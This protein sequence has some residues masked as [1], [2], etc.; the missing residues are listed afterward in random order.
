MVGMTRVMHSPVLLSKKP[1]VDPATSLVNLS[2]GYPFVYFNNELKKFVMFY[3]GW[4]IDKTIIAN[5]I[6]LCAS[7]EDGINFI[8]LDTSP[9]FHEENKILFNQVLPYKING[10]TFSEGQFFYLPQLKSDH[11]FVALCMYKDSKNNFFAVTFTSN[12]GLRFTFHPEMAWHKGFNTPDYPMSIIYNSRL[13]SF[14]IYRRPRHT[15]R[16][17]AFVTT[18]DFIN[19]SDS[20]VILQADALDKPLTDF[21]GINVFHY[22]DQ[23]IG[24]LMTYQTPNY[25]RYLGN[26]ASGL[27]G[28]K[29][30]GGK[31]ETQLVYGDSGIYFNRFLRSNFFVNPNTEFNCIYPTCLIEK[32]DKLLIYASSTPEEH[33]RVAPGKGSTNVFEMRVDGFCSLET[34]TGIGELIT[35]QF[36]YHGGDLSFN[37]RSKSGYVK[38]QIGDSDNNVIQGFEYDNCLPFLG[39]SLSHVFSFKTAK[40]NSLKEKIIV[41]N[42]LSTS[43]NLY[44]ISGNIEFVTPFEAMKYE[45]R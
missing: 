18:K 24:F 30:D 28:H 44:S 35:K 2:W 17:I 36:L 34:N 33:G 25:L 4:S 23:Y 14:V 20:E 38:I 13:D 15:D 7:S 43:A 31:V 26:R 37:I 5:V 6:Q 42:V 3:Q 21:Y 22:H 19:Y 40:L 16:R 39:D 10:L 32:K 45:G 41:I 1:Y 12:D 27:P 29:F 8:P 11:K 9:Y